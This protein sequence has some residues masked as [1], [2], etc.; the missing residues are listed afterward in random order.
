MEDR[1]ADWL[2]SYGTSVGPT[3]NR[4]K[5][6]E[7]WG[8][9]PPTDAGVQ[10]A[11]LFGSIED[12]GEDVEDRDDVMVGKVEFRDGLE[13]V[14]APE[15]I[16]EVRLMRRDVSEAVNDEEFAVMDAVDSPYVV[17]E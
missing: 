11:V 17:L 10:I 8:M 2:R 6:F 1:R 13:V 16:E 9:G 15:L 5:P 7:G 14:F 3:C 4:S 12:V